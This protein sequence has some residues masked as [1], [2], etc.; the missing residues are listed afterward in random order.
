MLG[1]KCLISG[2]KSPS[3]GDYPGLPSTTFFLGGCNAKCKNCEYKD[4]EE[5]TLD[6]LKTRIE[7]NEV[8]A[9]FIS[10]CEPLAQYEVCEEIAMLAKK[11]KLKVGLETLGLYEKNLRKL[12]ENKLVDFVRLEIRAPLEYEHYKK[13]TNLTKTELDSIKSSIGLLR[14]SGVGY[15]FYTKLSKDVGIKEAEKLYREIL[16]CRLYVVELDDSNSSLDEFAH[17]RKGKENVILRV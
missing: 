12:I 11:D 8:D 10:G 3:M 4:A 1:M 15:E 14:A 2:I 6:E 17:F 7:P 5:K 16:P 9:V 13:I